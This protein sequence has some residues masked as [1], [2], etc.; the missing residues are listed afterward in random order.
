MYTSITSGK[1]YIGKTSRSISKRFSQHKTSSK[2][3]STTHFHKALRKYTDSD[4]TLTILRDNITDLKILSLLE[5]FYISKHNTYKCGYNQ[6]KGGDRA[7]GFTPTPESVN[8]MRQ[9]ITGKGHPMYG[10]K[11]PEHSA[12]MKGRYVGSL[13]PR[14]GVEVSQET[15]DKIKTSLK[16]CNRRKPSVVGSKNPRALLI[17]IYNADDALVYLCN[18]NFKEICKSHNLPYQALKNLKN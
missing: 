16:F 11:R 5:V 14:Y 18:G 8:K 17:G 4:F 2:A 9:K 13:N 12:Y 7:K 10:K 3:G 15:R 1:S 6:T